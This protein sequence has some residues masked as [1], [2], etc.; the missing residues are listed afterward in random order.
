MTFASERL[1]LERP[2]RLSAIEP[3]ERDIGVFLRSRSMRRLGAWMGDWLGGGTLLVEPFLC[4][5]ITLFE[6]GQSA[7]LERSVVCVGAQ[8]CGTLEALRATS[9]F[10]HRAAA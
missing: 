7:G 1:D 5:D 4:S 10:P 2:L 3:E 6:M 8:V 9:E